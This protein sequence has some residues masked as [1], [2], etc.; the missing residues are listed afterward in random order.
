M[1]KLSYATRRNKKTKLT[2]FYSL[3]YEY[4]NDCLKASL[5]YNKDYYT[6]R[7][8]RPEENLFF[9]ITIIPFAESSSPNL[10]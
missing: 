2:E 9:K 5:E 1:N 8:L 10:K 6:D 4:Q 7:D 3:I